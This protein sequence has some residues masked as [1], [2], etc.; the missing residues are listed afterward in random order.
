MFRLR[1][2]YRTSRTEWFFERKKN[3]YVFIYIY[4]HFQGSWFTGGTLSGTSWNGFYEVECILTGR[5]S[6]T[7]SFIR[8]RVKKKKNDN[9]KTVLVHIRGT[10]KKNASVPARL[11]LTPC[12]HRTQYGRHTWPEELFIGRVPL[13]IYVP[14][15]TLGHLSRDGL[16]K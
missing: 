11:G 14:N 3:V 7:F 6:N 8:P 13:F 5:V 1:V 4:I 9:N 15:F 10:R 16:P 2:L 12:V